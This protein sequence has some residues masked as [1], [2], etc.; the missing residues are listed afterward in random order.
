MCEW[1]LSHRKKNRT[2]KRRGDGSKT[3][4]KSDK[5]ARSGS[6]T[7]KW[8]SRL[9]Y[10]ITNGLYI[11]KQLRNHTHSPGIGLVKDRKIGAEASRI[12]NGIR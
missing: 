1:K 3:E 5:L 10:R 4:K 8:R 7:F 6:R 2:L 12:V 9:S 11:P